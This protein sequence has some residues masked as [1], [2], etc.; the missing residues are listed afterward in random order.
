MHLRIIIGLHLYRESGLGRSDI[1]LTPR[2]SKGDLA[3]VIEFK[4]GAIGLALEHYQKIAKDA[5][6]QIKEKKYDACFVDEPNVKR[7]LN[8]ALV[9]YGKEFVCEWEFSKRE[10]YK[11]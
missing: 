5:L 9:F 11:I 6:A 3:I 10:E 1:V 7:I 2:E 8:F 4:K